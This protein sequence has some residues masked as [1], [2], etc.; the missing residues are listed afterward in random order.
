MNNDAE[1]LAQ[2]PSDVSHVIN[3]L[4]ADEYQIYKA[5]RK[6]QREVEEIKIN[7]LNKFY[8]NQYEILENIIRS[9]SERV[10]K[11]GNSY[12]YSLDDLLKAGRIVA[13]EEKI[14]SKNFII[15]RLHA[16]H[17]SLIGLLRADIIKI[18][19]VHKDTDTATFLSQVLEKHEKIMWMLESHLP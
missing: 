18:A 5:T 8:E 16:Y 12:H 4:L 13:L 10:H 17:E 3:V 2:E 11:N 15:E 19:E 6:A 9:T 14:Y 7:G 1:F